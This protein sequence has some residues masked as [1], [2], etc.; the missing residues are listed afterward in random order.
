MFAHAKEHCAPKRAVFG[1]VCCARVAVCAPLARLSQ[2]VDVRV[3][4]DAKLSQKN[5]RPTSSARRGPSAAA[6]GDDAQAHKKHSPPACPQVARA[7]A[8][9]T[10]DQS[11]AALR[12]CARLSPLLSPFQ[13]CKPIR[14]LFARPQRARLALTH[15]TTSAPTSSEGALT[16]PARNFRPLP[17]PPLAAH[18]PPLVRLR[19]A[20]PIVGRRPPP[21]CRAASD[22]RSQPRRLEAPRKCPPVALFP[23]FP[24]DCALRCGPPSLVHASQPHRRAARTELWP[25]AAVGPLQSVFCKTECRAN[26]SRGTVRA[27]SQQPRGAP[28]N[29]WGRTSTARSPHAT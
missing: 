1:G 13:Q 6:A 12:S 22:S 11:S 3:S 25:R 19:P 29:A 16:F 7:L 26:R 18:V 14:Q 21:E 20:P 24:S 8:A 15:A 23:P 9:R 17:V 2:A 10:S 5:S 27:R 4:G 28:L